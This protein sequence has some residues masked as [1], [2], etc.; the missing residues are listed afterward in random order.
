MLID[1][2]ILENLS[3]WDLQPGNTEGTELT[4]HGMQRASEDGGLLHRPTSEELAE[5]EGFYIP[6]LLQLPVTPALAR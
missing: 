1:Y 5:R 6:A 3:A 4:T 2:D